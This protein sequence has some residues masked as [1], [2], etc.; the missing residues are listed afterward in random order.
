M[1]T[2]KDELKSMIDVFYKRNDLAFAIPIK[3]RKLLY[4]I[5]EWCGDFDLRDMEAGINWTDEE[6]VNGPSAFAAMLTA[7]ERALVCKRLKYKGGDDVIGPGKFDP[8]DY[9]KQEEGIEKKLSSITGIKGVP[10]SYVTRVKDLADAKDL[11]DKPFIMKTVLL[12]PLIG[13]SFEADSRE[14]H[15]IV[16]ASTTG[17]DAEQ[18]LKSVAKYE[19]G[20]RDMNIIRDFYEGTG[21]NNRRMLEAKQSL[22]HIHYKNERTMPY[23]IFV[24]K[25]T[26]IFQVLSDGGQ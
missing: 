17:T 21:S 4:D 24:E 6:I 13:T 19:C 7:R 25:L 20:C 16:V 15:Q 10:I 11:L 9:V 8:T 3:R 23:A 14:V 1:S 2:T 5:L 18:F 26:D 22:K 12:T